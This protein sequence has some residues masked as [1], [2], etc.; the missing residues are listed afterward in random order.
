V[1]SLSDGCGK[2]SKPKTDA[3]PTHSSNTFPS[4]VSLSTEICFGLRLAYPAGDGSAAILRSMPPNSRRVDGRLPPGWF[5]SSPLPGSASTL[6]LHRPWALPRAGLD[7]PFGA[8]KRT[9]SQTRLN[10]RP[11][12]GRQGL[13]ENWGTAKFPR[14]SRNHEGELTWQRKYATFGVIRASNAVIQFF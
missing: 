2:I 11:F 9:D 7:R 1:Q 14:R 6:R 5:L 10:P 12:A 13:Q 3:S 8:G 4:P